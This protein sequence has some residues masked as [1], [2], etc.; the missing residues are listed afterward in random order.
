MPSAAA[1]TRSSGEV[2]KPRTS[3]AL[4]P[5]YAV[6]TVMA[7]FSLRGYWRTLSVRTACRPA[8]TINRLTTM[9][10]TG[11]RMKRS[12]KLIGSPVGRLGVDLHVR[13]EIVFH[14]QIHAVAQ[15]ERAAR[16][17][18]LAGLQ[19]G[20]H[21]DEVAPSH[22]QPH[23]FLL[24]DELRLVAVFLL[25]HDEDRVAVGRVEHRRDRD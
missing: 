23:E 20:L 13:S 3:A 5:T 6:V 24:R 22:A 25:V 15:L 1:M 2:M 11:R 10:T 4:A 18:G 14:E 8:I 17:H 7:A 21:G 16:D 12:V 19:A 9:A